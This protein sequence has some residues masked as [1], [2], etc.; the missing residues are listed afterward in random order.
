MIHPGWRL[1]L[2]RAWSV[3]LIALA[4]VLSVLPVFMSLVDASLLG[5]PPVA[6]AALSALASLGAFVARFIVQPGAGL[7]A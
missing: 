1:I 3:K 4:G 5:I 6:F 2:R 7:S